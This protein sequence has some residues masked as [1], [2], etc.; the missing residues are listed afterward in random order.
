[1]TRTDWVPGLMILGGYLLGSIPFGVVVSRGLGTVDPR[2]AGSGNIGFTNVL[3]VSG[4]LAGVLTL[5]GDAGKGWV[6]GAFAARLV[7]DERW[8]LAIALS[9]ILGHLYSVFLGFQ[10]GKGVATAL[11]AV[12]GVDPWIGLALLAVWLITWKL[13][14][15]SSAAAIAA[16]VSLP[17]IGVIAGRGWAFLA[18]AGAVTG[19]IVARHRGNLIRLWRGIEP[20]MT[21]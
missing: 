21:S 15:Y 20:R 18:F 5:A 7:P 9:A 19:L 3:R 6:V 13:W 8:V 17:A 1:M 2:T 16:F 12:T 10:G 14:G 4:R 11:G